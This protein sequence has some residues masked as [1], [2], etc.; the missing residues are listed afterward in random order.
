VRHIMS[1][2][3][4]LKLIPRRRQLGV[5]FLDRRGCAGEIVLHLRNFESCEE[6][7]FFHAIADIDINLANISRHLCHNV[8]LLIR[9]E[10]RG[11]D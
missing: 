11:Q 7:S 10:F 1:G 5:R 2:L 6:L 4:A 3:G 9:R 8:D